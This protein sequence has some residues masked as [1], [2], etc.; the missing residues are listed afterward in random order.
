MFVIHCI[1]T[2]IE[3]KSK[4]ILDHYQ[5][6]AINVTVR[7]LR[8]MKTFSINNEKDVFVHKFEENIRINDKKK[9]VFRFLDFASFS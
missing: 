3:F 1:N 8:F 6:T 4:P 5:Y 9:Y 7:Q 2:S